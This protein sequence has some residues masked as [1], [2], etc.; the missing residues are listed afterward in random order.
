MAVTLTIEDGTGVANA[1]TFVGLDDVRAYATQRGITSLPA[2]D[3]ALATLI[4]S[5]CD[6]VMTYESRMK[7]SRALPDTQMLCYP[8]KCVNLFGSDLAENVIPMQLK[9]AQILV[10]IAASTGISLF[11][12]QT[13]A[14]VTRETIGPIT[15]EYQVNS[16]SDSNLPVFSN[17]DAAIDPL[18]ANGSFGKSWI[19][20]RA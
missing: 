5:A 1:N 17:V 8:R 4:L 11:P 20:V 9:T 19:T 14:Q 6:Y 15:T 2:T 7:G 18:L 16:W 13:G 12:T 3:D 10:T